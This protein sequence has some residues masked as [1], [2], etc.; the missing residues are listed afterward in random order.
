MLR[1]NSLRVLI[2]PLLSVLF[3]SGSALAHP[4]AFVECKLTFVFDKD[5][6]AGFQQRWLL[7]EMLTLT[8]LELVDTN[9]DFAISPEESRKTGEMTKENLKD[10]NFYTGVR[11]DGNPFQVNYITDFK[12]GMQGNKLVYS[13]FTPCHVKAYKDFKEIKVAVYDKTFY[14]YVAYSQ[15]GKEL[16][17]KADPFFTATQAPA[18]PEDYKR[19]SEAVGLEGYNGDVAISGD[20]NGLEI[21]TM[22]R[23]AKEFAYFYDQIIPEA[24]I[25]RFKK[26]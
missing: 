25:L 2:L 19:F 20:T 15:E 17:P 4:H 5:G 23:E 14:T 16:D 11:I 8:I 24:F 1:L 7:D 9:H 12:A 6:L 21:E 13:F 26:K 3:F 22:V 10:F 18:S